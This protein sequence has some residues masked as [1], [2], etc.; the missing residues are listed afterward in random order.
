M[1]SNSSDFLKEIEAAQHDDHRWG[2][3]LDSFRSKLRVMVDLRMHALVRGRVDPSDIIQEAF[4]DAS[5][6]LPEYVAN[7]VVPF[8][9]WLR[10]LT[11]QRL[12]LAHRRNLGTQS[13]NAIRE[14]SMFPSAIQSA[15]SAAIAAQLVG[16]LTSPSSAAIAAEQKLRL[17]AALEELEPIDREILVLRHFEEMTNAES[18]AVLDLRPTAASNRY[19]R[20]LGKLKLVLDRRLEN[21]SEFC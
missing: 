15:T 14:V 6:R 5:Q 4:V 18:A 8:Y 16:K 19:V 1:E 20:A 21:P 2:M 12:S 11:A 9:V 3:L 17:E 7:P 10:S 13:R